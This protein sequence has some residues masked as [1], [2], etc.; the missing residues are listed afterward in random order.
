MYPPNL[1]VPLPDPSALAPQQ[2]LQPQG[3]LE[4][5][6]PLI[7]S[8]FGMGA[9]LGGSPTTGAAFLQGSHQALQQREQQK[10]VK[11][12]QDQQLQ[13]QQ[14]AMEMQAI[15]R[16]QQQM[17]QI[18]AAKQKLVMD[19]AGKARAAKTRPEYE[20]IIQEGE[21]IGA[22]FLGM[23]PNTIRAAAPYLAPNANTVMSEA[24]QAFLKNPANAQAIEQGKLDGSILLD[25]QGD[26][27]PIKVPVKD[28]LA[29]GGVQ[30][31]P[32]TGIPLVLPKEA[33]AS[34]NVQL[35]DEAF[36]GEVSKFEAEKGRPATPAE[37][38][39]IALR[40]RKEI[41]AA[42]RAPAAPSDGS[43]PPRM[44]TQVNGIASAFRSEPV[45]KR[46]NTIAEAVSFVQSLPQN[47][48][49]P[50]DDQALIYAFAKAMD[51]ESVVREGEYAT[52]QKYAQSWLDNFKFN[53]ARIINNQ[54]FLTPQARANM[55]A[56]IL[57]RYAAAKTQYDNVRKGFARQVTAATSGK[58]DPEDYLMDYAG[59]FPNAQTGAPAQTPPQKSGPSGF[60]VTAPN[61]KTYRF[62]SQQQL[63]AFKRAAG[64]Q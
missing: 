19:Y 12:R 50:A 23:R 16:Q 62:A 54:E 33:K 32:Q 2:T 3:G 42:G 29:A 10:Q 27:I 35:D 44:Q 61:G 26:G 39:S 46:T 58:A 41:A 51:P 18:E 60:S 14:Q 53:A 48:N 38:G 7:T 52:V 63:D 40:V 13:L 17:A 31:D 22:S 9:A 43:L 11:A 4:R 64:I 28:V 25:V 6:I 45:V 55:K 15:Q 1:N 49:S 37:R 59:A 30:L 8:L 56:T 24:A 36:M 21:N 57:K 47:S 5:A 20:S 34:G